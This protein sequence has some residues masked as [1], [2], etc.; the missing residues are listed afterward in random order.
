MRLCP[1]SLGTVVENG[2]VIYT[3]GLR[4]SEGYVEG[5]TASVECRSGYEREGENPVCREDGT[6]SS[7]L[8]SCSEGNVE[9]P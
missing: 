3:S 9:T 6:W 4:D 2:D 1:N 7:A 8:A 5:T